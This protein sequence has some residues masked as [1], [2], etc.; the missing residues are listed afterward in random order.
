LAALL[1]A[2]AGILLL[3]TGFLL[4]APLLL[5]LS[6]RSLATFLLTR[7]LIAT[8]ILLNI[9]VWISHLNYLIVK[10]PTPAASY[11]LADYKA[12][13]KTQMRSHFRRQSTAMPHQPNA[14]TRS[15]RWRQ[16]A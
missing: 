4:S 13:K 6:W 8:L 9:F 12:D 15:M 16:T 1:A 5:L 2:F 11:E 7:L 14:Y 10:M 3:L